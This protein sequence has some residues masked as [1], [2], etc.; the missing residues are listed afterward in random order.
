MN[1]I[2]QLSLRIRKDPDDLN[3]WKNIMALVNDPKKKRDCQKQIDRII[4]KQQVTS[5][6]CP[7]CGGGMSIYF[8]GELHDKRAK[9]SYC[10][11]DVDIPDTYLK[12]VVEKRTGF[13][14][15]LPE[16]EVTV[17]ERRTDNDGTMVNSEEINKLIVEKGLIAA[18]K[19]L[20]ARGIK[21]LRIDDF[22]GIDKSSEANR[23]LEQDG[24]KAFAKSQGAIFVTPQQ[25][26]L[27]FKGV[28]I[29]FAI[30]SLVEI[31]VL[32]FRNF[33]K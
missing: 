6:I 26:K 9:C 13:G 30:L 31:I 15:L 12:T 25:A 28:I 5:I 24:V 7:Q 21:G 27:I 14:Q 4:A 18:R 22:S 8:V 33:V 2:E 32:L 29:F 23:I 20:E 10:G 3:A 16:T 17:Y 11:T 19:E 1:D